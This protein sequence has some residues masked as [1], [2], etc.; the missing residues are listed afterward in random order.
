MNKNTTE[1]HHKAER[2]EK[3]R[4]AFVKRRRPVKTRIYCQKVVLSKPQ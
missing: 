2:I 1:N 4:Q 3:I